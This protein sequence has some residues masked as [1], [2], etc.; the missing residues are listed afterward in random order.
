[1]SGN[2]TVKADFMR[3]NMEDSVY[4]AGIAYVIHHGIVRDIVQQEAEWNTGADNCPNVYANIML[5]LPAT[6]TYYTYQLRLMF[7]DST[8]SRNITDLCPIKLT[9][10]IDQLQTENGTVNGIPIVANGTGNFSSS[11]WAHHW[12]QFILG[13][14]G[15]G[16]MFTNASNQQLYVFDS[17]ADNSVGAL[18]VGNSTKTI[19]LLPVARYSANFNYALDVTWHGAVATFDSSATPIY[20]IQGTAPTGLWLLVEY[21]PTITVNSEN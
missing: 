13:S 11:V 8:Q 20:A 14:Q 12:S 16:I 9:T 3:I 15:A 17:I 19:G 7:I 10:S 5:S 18:K 4:G 2:S 6:A 1:V 21:Q